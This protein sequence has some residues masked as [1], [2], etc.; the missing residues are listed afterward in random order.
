MEIPAEVRILASIRSGSVFYF[1]EEEVA[2]PEAHYFVV[3]NKDPRTDEML[4]L[5]CASSR[6]AKRKA[7]VNRLGFPPETLVLITSAEYPLFTKDTVIDCNR[8]FEKTPQ[9]LIDKLKFGKLK[10]C[11]EVMDT[12][13]VDKLKKG[14]A[15]SSQITEEVKKILRCENDG[16]SEKS[17]S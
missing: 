2:S 14:I 1:E 6:V 8:A 16:D 10:V 4:I 11:T 15:A 13:I 3:L 17:D 5:V 9:S 12:G 7:I